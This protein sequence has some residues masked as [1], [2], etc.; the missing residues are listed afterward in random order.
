[1]QVEDLARRRRQRRPALHLQQAGR[2][3]AGDLY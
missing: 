1:M 2:A 3:P